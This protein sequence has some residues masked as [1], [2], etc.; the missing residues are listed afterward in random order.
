MVVYV[1]NSEGSHL[2]RPEVF[3]PD[4][5][6]KENEAIV[7]GGGIWM[8]AARLYNNPNHPSAIADDVTRV[9]PADGSELNGLAATLVRTVRANKDVLLLVGLGWLLFE[10]VTDR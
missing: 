10:F 6:L 8:P 9:S 2:W 7:P 5:V 1:P 4:V 3:L